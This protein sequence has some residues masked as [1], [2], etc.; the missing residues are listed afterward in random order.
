MAL[1]L[2]GI[3]FPVRV[4]FVAVFFANSSFLKDNPGQLDNCPFS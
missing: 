2:D 1:T 3:S 4:S